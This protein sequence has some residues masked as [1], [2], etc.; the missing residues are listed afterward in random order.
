MKVDLYNQQGE[1][2]GTALLPKELFDVP[3]NPDLVHQVVVSQMGNRRK[4]IAHTKGRGEVKGGGRK[5]WRQ[6]GTG[7]ARHGS[8]RSPLWRGGGV[9]FGPTKEKVFKKEIPKKMKRKA[10]F[11]VLSAKAKNNLLIILD[12]LKME[13]P[14]TKQLAELIENWKLKIENFKAG[15]VLIALPSADKN[16]IL[17]A[18]N[19]AHAKTLQA[20]DLNALDLLSSKYVVMPK[21]AIKVVK[22]TFIKH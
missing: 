20:K 17:A 10:L 4:V 12:N 13:K 22:E 16:I 15:S 5:P 18:R 8:I 21:D 3:L 2:I 1:K 7:R 6:K 9:A 19:L 14:K 11:M